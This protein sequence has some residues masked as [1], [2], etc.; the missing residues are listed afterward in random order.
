MIESIE[1]NE[2]RHFRGIL[3]KNSWK[4]NHFTE[5]TNWERKQCFTATFRYSH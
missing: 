5:V 2:W 1:L 3:K 4:M